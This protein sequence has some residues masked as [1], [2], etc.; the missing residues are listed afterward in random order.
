MGY[1]DDAPSCWNAPHAWQLGWLRARQLDGASLAP[2]ATL[3]LDLAPL[4]A[5]GAL[6]LRLLPSWAPGADALF[7]SY[8]TAPAGSPDA[9]LAAAED[10]VYGRLAGRVHVHT[11]STWGGPDG[12]P[13]AW[14]AVLGGA[15]PLPP[16]P[17]S[18]QHLLLYACAPQPRR[19]PAS[20]R[21]RQRL[22]ERAA[23]PLPPLGQ[24]ACC[25]PPQSQ[26]KNTPPSCVAAAGQ[27][28]E[29]PEAGVVLRVT[30][31]RGD[32]AAVTVC[33]KAGAETA[34]SCAAG[35]DADCNGLA[36]ARDPACA[37]LRIAALG[38]GRRGGGRVRRPRKGRCAA[39]NKKT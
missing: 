22:E 11:A 34:A 4:A 23:R 29:Y 20:K 9:G 16:P 18:Q 8:R 3:A 25:R 5:P 26:H 17:A 1:A 27:A 6:A 31:L 2:G 32:A 24:R 12:S 39:A 33:R 38:E 19:P 14:R 10:G 15:P 21:H 13:T 30:A 35:V 37:A 36:G 7:A 28:W